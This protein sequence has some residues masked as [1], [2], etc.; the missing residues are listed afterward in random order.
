MGKTAF[1]HH[2]GILAGFNFNTNQLPPTSCCLLCQTGRSPP[3]LYLSSLLLTEL[4]PGSLLTSFTQPALPWAS[5]RKRPR[6]RNQKMKP[7][8]SVPQPD[9]SSPALYLPQGRTASAP[10]PEFTAKIYSL[11]FQVLRGKRNEFP[12]RLQ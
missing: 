3:A 7:Y 6:L 9:Q 12:Q 11:L 1:Y 2:I 4:Q 5:S 10:G 8:S